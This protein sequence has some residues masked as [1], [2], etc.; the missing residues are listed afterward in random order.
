[1][2][3][4]QSRVLVIED[5]EE[6]V[7][8]YKEWLEP[9]G[10]E[11][12]WATDAP[13]GLRQV[14]SLRPD[15]ILLDLRVP[16]KQSVE[17]GLELL[18]QAREEHPPAK[19][20]ITT[21]DGT[22]TTALAAIRQGATDYLIKPIDPDVLLVVIS[23]SLERRWLEDQ[24]RH[25]QHQLQVRYTFEGMIGKSTKMQEVIGLVEKAASTSANVLLRGESG[26]G[27]EL[28]ARAI[29]A[30][31]PRS[32]APFVTLN[33]AALPESLLESELFGHERGAYTDAKRARVGLVESAHGGTI[34]LDEIGD[35]PPSTQVKLL[36]VLQER[37]ITRLG[38]NRPIQVDVRVISATNKNLENLRNEGVFREDLYYRL[39]AFA[40]HLPRLRSRGEDIHLLA[41]H[42]LAKYC[43]ADRKNVLGF[44]P[45]AIDVLMAYSWPG[46]V[47][48]LE[49]EI[50]GAIARA[51]PDSWIEPEHF[52]P[53]LSNIGDVVLMAERREGSLSDILA[54]V[55][56]H[57]IREKL[58]QHGGNRTA[59][60]KSL[61]ISRV[62]LHQKMAK[63]GIE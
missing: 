52:S 33:C 25:L 16:P 12:R 21:A 34:F 32:E 24:V 37:E 1:M 40:L 60:A 28:V 56:Q 42:F 5:D 11:V 30:R 31:G 3:K 54:R 4:R 59:T 23:R 55:E 47:R 57:V 2:E 35:L 19:V 62:N 10:Y 27:K 48:E 45:D 14:R 44:S 20:V 17:G 58:A 13:E 41:E 6:Y 29:H 26:T 49:N 39:S 53:N 46:N 18:R 36:R 51:E 61:G 9:Q 7:Q 50:H 43:Q 22:K 8:T 15:L 38:G 63:Y